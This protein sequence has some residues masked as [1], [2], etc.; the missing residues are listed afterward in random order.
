MAKPFGLNGGAVAFDS[1]GREPL[2]DAPW[3]DGE[4]R[5]DGIS[6]ALMPRLRR[7]T[8]VSPMR[9]RGSRPWLTPHGVT[10]NRGAMALVRR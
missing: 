4:S 1:Q 7:S 10:G 5:S 3:R 9:T 6:A 2:V 8:F